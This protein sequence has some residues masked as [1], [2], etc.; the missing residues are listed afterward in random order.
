MGSLIQ[1]RVQQLRESCY[2]NLPRLWLIEQGVRK[3]DRL[4]MRTNEEGELIVSP[5]KEAAH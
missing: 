3:G 2:I 4:E 1:R 5:P